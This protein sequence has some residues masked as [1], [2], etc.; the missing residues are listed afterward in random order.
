MPHFPGHRKS[1][2]E[3]W[4]PN[5]GRLQSLLGRGQGQG[6]FG[7]NIRQGGVDLRGRVNL[8]GSPNQSAIKGATSYLSSISAPGNR[9][10]TP[11]STAVAPRTFGTGG[12]PVADIFKGAKIGQ[13]GA[14]VGQPAAPST[15]G[16]FSQ[17]G[18]Q[19]AQAQQVQGGPPT[20]EEAANAVA[21][22]AGQAEGP[23]GILDPAQS[24][25]SRMV[26]EKGSGKRSDIGRS[27]MQAG[28]RMMKGSTEG[29]F[30]TIGE[31]LETGLGG[32]QALKED[33]RVQEDRDIKQSDR[34]RTL[35]AVET[36]KEGLDEDQQATIDA[37]I[38]TGDYSKAGD[39]AKGY[40]REAELD[41]VFDLAGGQYITDEYEYA[42][43][44][45][46]E[47]E[48]RNAY[49]IAL[50]ESDKGLKGRAMA[51][52][53]L[54]PN[55]SEDDALIL[56]EDAA[57]V[58]RLMQRPSDMHIATDG[59]GQNYILNLDPLVDD[60]DRQVGG[61]YGRARIDLTAEQLDIQRA[62][63]KAKDIEPMFGSIQDSY[64]NLLPRFHGL[65]DYERALDI[66]DRTVKE[67]DAVGPDGEPLHPGMAEPFIGPWADFK[68]D[69]SA[70]W[71]GERAA[72]TQELDNILLKLGIGN[73]SNFRGAISEKE[74]EQALKAAGT[75]GELQ[76][77]LRAILAGAVERQNNEMDLHNENV[78]RLGPDGHNIDD[79]DYWQ[80]DPE[81]IRQMGN[82]AEREPGTGVDKTG[83]S[84]IDFEGGS[85]SG[86]NI[87]ERIEQE[88][89]DELVANSRRRTGGGL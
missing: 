77:S 65:E 29:T 64:A 47:P 83:T 19:A 33:R 43:V 50:R 37:Y 88:G 14:R 42:T 38:A 40:A 18:P 39:L 72:T 27:M 32:Y 62:A 45:A 35:A 16:G 10:P 44:K 87:D 2:H 71:G 48:E 55:L 68:K 6:L 21:A 85:V 8:I 53:Q 36:L 60:D 82:V 28:A 5:P 49:L 84:G 7:P 76:V 11:T 86:M 80:L 46:M 57:A 30:A 52:R 56:A 20:P 24:F 34:E 58:D 4:N 73:L 70:H 3:P 81:R 26:G 25:F 66:L 15:L 63:A 41:E 13:F 51:I 79:W 89:I 75:V 61:P 78:D 31:G 22:T 17:F 1:L 54:R 23:E 67:W 9:L 69:V 74:M 59:R 12:T